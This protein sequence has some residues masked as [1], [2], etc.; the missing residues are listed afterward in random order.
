[1]M[2]NRA[3]HIKLLV[4]M[5]FCCQLFKVKAQNVSIN[6]NGSAPD[7]SA[8]L[9]VSDTTKGLL[10][11]RLTQVQRDAIAG[12]ATGLLIFQTDADSGF[13]FNLGIPS[14]PNWLK[15]ISANDTRSSISDADGNTRILT[16]QTAN[17]DTLRFFANGAEVMKI[18]SSA[19]NLLKTLVIPFTTGDSVGVIYQDSVR[20]LHT[21]QDAGAAFGRNLYLGHFAGNFTQDA[22]A[23]LNT[24]MGWQAMTSVTSGS[25]NAAYG[26]RSLDALETGSQNTALGYNSMRNDTVGSYNTGV[27]AA[28]LRYNDGDF[29][30]AIGHHAMRLAFGK[31]MSN[32]AIGTQALYFE[33][34][35]YNV[36]VGDS[37]GYNNIGGIRN[38][39]I[40]SKAGFKETGDN[41]LYIAN[42]STDTPLIW[43]DFANDSIKIYGTLSIGDSTTFPTDRGTSGQVLT[44]N[45]LGKIGWQTPSS[46][47]F[48]QDVDTISAGSG[49]QKFV[50]GSTNTDSL[51]GTTDDTRMFFDL[52][53]A[54]FRVGEA[55]GSQWDA[56]NRG[57]GSMAMGSNT[58]ASGNFSFAAGD[59]TSALG[60]R[61][62]AMG[63]NS[64]AGASR[65]IAMGAS[66]Y[67]GAA[68][69]IAIGEL[70]TALGSNSIAMGRY[71]YAETDF[72]V[73]IGEDV[74]AEGLESYAIGRELI[75]ESMGEIVL[76]YRNDTLG[77]GFS[78]GGRTA[79]DRL[80]VI[81]N[82]TNTIT[83]SNALVMLKNGNT[84]LNGE[85]T[86][87]SLFVPSG[88]V[89][90]GTIS[91]DSLLDVVGGAE[92]D[93]LSIG[94]DY[95][96]PTS[97]PA[98]T[99][100]LR[101]NGSELEWGTV[102][103]ASVWA[104]SGSVAYYNTGAVGI[105]IATPAADLEI[106][107][108]GPADANNAQFRITNSTTG[109]K[110]LMGRTADY[111]FI[112]NHDLE[113]LA[114]N[115]LGNNVGI[116]ITTPHAP[117]QFAT[118]VANRKIVLYE[119]ADNDH[120]FYGFGVQSNELR[121]QTDGTV[122][123]H[124]FY[125]STSSSASDELFRITG[126]GNIG[127]NTAT[128]DEKLHIQGNQSNLI[129]TGGSPHSVM[130]HGDL[131][132][133][134]DE[135]DNSTGEQLIIRSDSA[136]TL[137]V[138]EEDGDVGIG[139]NAPTALLSVNSAGHSGVPGLFLTGFSTSEGDIAWE[140]GEDL[141]LGEWSGS[142]FTQHAVIQASTG[143]LGLG[144]NAP[145]YNLHV[146]GSTSS[147]VN[148]GIENQNANGYSII[149]FRNDAGSE[150]V[151]FHNGSTR[152]A[153]GGAGSTTLRNDG[154][155]D[156]ILTSTSADLVL[157]PNGRN[158]GIGTAAPSQLLHVSSTTAGDAN[159][160]IEADT[161]NNN[162]SDNPSIVFQQDGGAVTGR[163]GFTGLLG[164]TYTNSLANAIHMGTDGAFDLQLYT[165]AVARLTIDENGDAGF[166][167]NAPS[168]TLQVE[169]NQIDA[170]LRVE[171]NSTDADADGIGVY[172]GATTPGASN[173]WL[174]FYGNGVT[175]G[176]VA[177]NGA[178]GTSFTTTS[179]RRLKTNIKDISNAM[180]MI[181][182]MQ[183]RV[184]NRIL[185]PSKL[186]YGFIAQELQDVY[187]QAV[188]GTP[189][190][191]PKVEPM[192]VDYGQLTPV[193]VKAVQEL[194]ERLEALEKENLAKQ[195]RIEA[196]EEQLKK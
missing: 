155:G 91:P 84:T 145:D 142:A 105:G 152:S 52:T 140:S 108:P 144:I 35:I 46:D 185:N 27:G 109:D 119:G 122:S 137:M 39:F 43:G 150:A 148:M 170:I 36:A 3:I 80:L 171:N 55:N 54:S 1:M 182:G 111:G 33:Q 118:A 125:A 134:I 51:D 49:D 21:Y 82:S 64:T 127:I 165:N 151:L 138:V 121:Y 20:L 74:R 94:G 88:N 40:G 157:Q 31:P 169:D 166:G 177:G 153:D 149:R 48:T 57:N 58:I 101:Y 73:A 12:P 146:R 76:G 147:E 130:S 129:F 106:Y 23:Q 195:K 6:D 63:R 29:N 81:G 162:E 44:S 38:V 10:V 131:I 90:I 168:T 92:I 60:A 164:E 5:I 15:L 86:T 132:L 25:S 124:V 13:Y 2:K 79:T 160:L 186:E 45:G 59:G 179:D 67:T 193:L 113:P 128:P 89:G 187:P 172:L 161:D 11:P 188:S 192:G 71:A 159:L 4:L 191:D 53:T 93:R 85:L 37:A 69:A 34:G 110:M 17:E 65:S 183:P 7:S 178:G 190:G 184:Y 96:F 87:N 26:Y 68:H 114:I 70:D 19:L 95:T 167:T 61:S 194:N 41:K 158:V 189:D 141:Q 100:V 62:I 32:V 136:T 123:D 18:D 107:A 175:M 181:S 47:I 78:A 16:E 97:A 120:Q 102:S 126:D 116:G 22:N 99:N 75:A 30:T 104:T 83:R 28:A 56:V 156:L 135:N 163:V 112:Q 50:F 143:R 66:S 103:S 154:S 133:D 77:S 24:G 180:G 196:L 173:G 176:S 174:F 14:T 98:A 139:T 9:D 117:L 72:S 115:P 8:M 42:D